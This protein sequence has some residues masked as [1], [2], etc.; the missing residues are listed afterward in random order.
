MS[1]RAL[2]VRVGIDSSD[3]G[4]WNA[5]AD[6]SS[7]HFIYVPIAETK[8]LRKG[9]DRFYDEIAPTLRALQQSLPSQLI[10]QRMHLD[11]D[12]STLTYGD[13]GRRAKQIN[14]LNRGDLLAF[15]ASLRD[16]Q[17]RRLVYALI[18]IFVIQDISAARNIAPPLWNQNA[19]TRRIPGA[20][21][22]VVRALPQVS[23]RFERFL[24]IGEYRNRA[25]RVT[26]PLLHTWGDLTVRD[27]YLQRSARLPEF[28]DPHKFYRWFKTR[29]VPLLHR[30]N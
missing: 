8:S 4:H 28:K 20:G 19:H 30:N 11:P 1:L 25:Y 21:D 24:P 17:T 18:G 12:F 23:G 3:D 26:R 9:F 2:L 16:T 7:G 13:Q 27:G 29:R 6:V 15:Y 5:P 14:G 22:I 10:R